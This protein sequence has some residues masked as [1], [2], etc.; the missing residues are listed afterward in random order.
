MGT[1]TKQWTKLDKAVLTHQTKTT[2]KQQQQTNKQTN[3]KKTKKKQKKKKK[4]WGW[5]GGWV[6]WG[7]GTKKAVVNPTDIL[8]RIS[9]FV[10]QSTHVGVPFLSGH[11]QLLCNATESSSRYIAI[12]LHC[13]MKETDSLTTFGVPSLPVCLSR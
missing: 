13:R 8:Y 11:G 12:Y 3:K 9:V 5:V 10:C 1:S 6:A 7:V 4:G 2:K